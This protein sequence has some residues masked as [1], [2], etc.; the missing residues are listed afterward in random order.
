MKVHHNLA[1]NIGGFLA[2]RLFKIYKRCENVL[3]QA[4]WT[5]VRVLRQFN[6]GHEAYAPHGKGHESDSDA[7]QV[8]SGPLFHIPLQS[9]QH[10]LILLAKPGDDEGLCH[11][12]QALD[13]K[14]EIAVQ[15]CHLLHRL[16]GM[17]QMDVDG[18]GQ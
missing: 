7:G 8:C 10:S 18:P 13:A 16:K 3:R 17:A 14:S 6:T 1:E 12:Q 11:F 9:Q 2:C 4:H 15:A 5:R